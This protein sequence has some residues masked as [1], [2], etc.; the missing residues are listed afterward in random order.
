MRT[1]LPHIGDILEYINL[2]LGGGITTIKTDF[3]YPV[4]TNFLEY[5]WSLRRCV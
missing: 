3:L 5:P 4:V 1:E 2:Y